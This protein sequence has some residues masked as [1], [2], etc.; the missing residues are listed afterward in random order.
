MS[1]IV[2]TY[3]TFDL[4]H[5]GHLN[6]LKRARAL[7][8][9]LAVGVSTDEFNSEKGKET[10][11]G[12]AD[13]I[14]IVS[15]LQCVDEVFPES[16]WD[17]KIADVRRFGADTFVMG[18]D[19]SGKFDFLKDS[20]NVVYLPRTKDISSTSLKMLIS[21]LGHSPIPDFKKVLHIISTTIHS[22]NGSAGPLDPVA[23]NDGLA[24]LGQAN[25][26]LSAF[27]VAG[28]HK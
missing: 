17:Q 10:I 21:S 20:C 24:K 23:G 2:L 3:G 14:E 28:G 5:I 22:F 4:F 26:E 25:Q 12:F 9:R 6:L 7:G 16:S 19:W 13:R 1:R 27:R 18:D 11:I 15:A 8:D